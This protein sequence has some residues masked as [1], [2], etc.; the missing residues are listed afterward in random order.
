MKKRSVK[1]LTLCA[2]CIALCA[3]L[4]RAFNLIPNGGKLFSPLHIPVLLCGLACGG[5]WGAL[6]GVLGPLLGSLIGAPP[7]QM[8]P[9][10][11]P[12]LVIYGLAGGVCMKFIRTGHSSLDV[13]I[14]LATAMLLGRIAGGIATVAVMALTTGVYTWQMFVAAYFVEAVPAIIVHIAVIPVLVF[15][16]ARSRLIPA[17]YPK[18]EQHG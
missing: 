4:P 9:R 6:C 3:V 8:L 13:Y 2:M 15:A 5:S 1:N 12:E 18:V 10:F 7:V 14:S 11:I 17:R 16:L